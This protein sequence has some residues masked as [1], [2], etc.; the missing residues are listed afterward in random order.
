MLSYILDTNIVSEII[1]NNPN[2]SVRRFLLE[3]RQDFLSVVTIH[4]LKYGIELLPK[5]KR[6]SI[7]EEKFIDLI[8]TF[9]KQIIPILSQDAKRA[10]ELRVKAKKQGLSLHLAD[11]LIAGTAAIHGLGVATRNTSDFIAVCDNLFN[12]WE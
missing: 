6:K 11:S 3:E 5:G 10:A 2:E 4:E 12:P 9:E 8:Y 7:I 1:K